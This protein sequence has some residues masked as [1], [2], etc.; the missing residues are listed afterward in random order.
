VKAYA[1]GDVVEDVTLKDFD[2]QE[3]TLSKSRSIDDAAA[4][5]AVAAAAKSSLGVDDVKPSDARE[6]DALKDVKGDVA[7][8]MAF[9]RAAGKP[10]GLVPAEADAKGWKS[11][12]D[13]AGWIK[14]AANAPIVFVCWAQTCPTSKAYEDRF[15]ALAQT[16]G[17]RFYLLA[18]KY[19]ETDDAIKK[20]VEAKGLPFRVLDDRELRLTERLGGKR[21]PHVFVLDAK[22]AVRYGGAVDDDATEEKPEASR[23]SWA[24]D[25]VVA[26]AADKAV[27]VLL[28]APVG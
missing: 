10:F 16:T 3:F 18:T 24:K 17:A 1:I 2:G 22:N 28:T 7:K 4:W 14:K 27:K 21:T 9:V 13:V 5:T 6:I 20:Y 12:G 25:A 11:L 19:T 23:A 8:R 15:E 26:V